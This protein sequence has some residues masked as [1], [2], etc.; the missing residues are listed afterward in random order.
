MGVHAILR[1]GTRA[2]HIA[3]ERFLDLSAPGSTRRDYVRYL[4]LTYGYYAAAH[5]LVL[6]SRIVG[7]RWPRPALAP[8]LERLRDDLRHCRVEPDAL[9][10]AGADLL[11]LPSPQALTGMAYVLE[12][13]ALGGLVLFKLLAQPMGYG[14]DRGASFL[15]GEGPETAR[16]WSALKQALD[17]LPF[18]DAQAYVDGAR[19]TFGGIHAWFAQNAWR[20]EDVSTRAETV[21]L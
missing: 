9:P 5:A 20:A 17:G 18:V 8:K 7:E 3:L 15:F 16:R 19:A 4:E 2:Q 14:Q 6:S 13:A 11:P 21:R 1:E 12:G 10:C